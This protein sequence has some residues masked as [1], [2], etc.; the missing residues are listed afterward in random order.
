M[1]IAG[2][3]GNHTR[4]RRRRTC[5]GKS[6]GP[7]RSPRKQP[8]RTIVEFIRAD[9]GVLPGP[10][11]ALPRTCGERRTIGPRKAPRCACP[12]PYSAVPLR[13]VDIWTYVELNTED[14]TINVAPR[15]PGIS[16]YARLR[17]VEECDEISLR[18]AVPS[19]RLRPDL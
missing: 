18:T 9:I 17:T 3:N 2:V 8:L 16:Q 7:E 19:A 11:L 14:A 6:R 4:S 12:R 13:P 15:G 10:H 1:E 5:A